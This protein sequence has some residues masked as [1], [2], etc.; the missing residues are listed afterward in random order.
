MQSRSGIVGRI[1]WGVVQ[2]I[3]LTIKVGGAVISHGEL[4]DSTACLATTIIALIH[5]FG[6]NALGSLDIWIDHIEKGLKDITV[7]KHIFHIRE[8]AKICK[9]MGQYIYP[10]NKLANEMQVIADKATKSTTAGLYRRM[11]LIHNLK[12]LGV[13]QESSNMEVNSKDRWKTV[14]KRHQ[15]IESATKRPKTKDSKQF[16]LDVEIIEP[17]MPKAY[18]NGTAMLRTLTI[19]DDSVDFKGT[20]Y[21]VKTLER[22]EEKLSFLVKVYT[23]KLDEKRNFWSF[24]LA[25][26]SIVQ[27]PMEA[28][29]SYYGLN[30]NN[31]E[32]MYTEMIP[33]GF[34]GIRYEWFIIGVVYFVLL[35]YM[36]KERTL[37][38]AT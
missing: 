23:D 25:V 38:I 27:F 5:N 33:G 20:E 7:S 19:G 29:T 4:I 11:E 30:F 32:E 16:I 2:K 24:L 3:Y 36:L 1:L 21:W 6:M 8:C 37:Y 22:Y 26:V 35:L 13:V 31:V 12:T 10:F 28:I 9:E 18:A 17:F 15:T 14:V 34:R